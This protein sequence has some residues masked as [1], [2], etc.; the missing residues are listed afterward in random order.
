MFAKGILTLILLAT[1]PTLKAQLVPNNTKLKIENINAEVSD[2]RGFFQAD[3]L[4]I[5]WGL[6]DFD[7]QKLYGEVD[8][9]GDSL[10]YSQGA[11]TLIID[12]LTDSP[13]QFLQNIGVTHLNFDF[14]HRKFLFLNLN[15]ASFD[16]NEQNYQIQNLEMSCQALHTLQVQSVASDIIDLLYPCLAN[17]STSM[18]EFYFGKLFGL[19]E[20]LESFYGQYHEEL[21]RMNMLLN[22]SHEINPEFI[23]PRKL[24]DFFLQIKDSNFNIQARARLVLNLRMLIE[25][26]FEFINQDDKE[27]IKIEFNKATLARLPLRRIIL[28]G[29]KMAG[30]DVRGNSLYIEL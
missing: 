21:Q 4:N 10:I 30:F 25:G 1:L 7:Y 15:R 11:K 17:S 24:T 18:D 29:L 28:Q 23:L 20:S 14:I 13:F 6:F 3:Y 2:Y 9:R 12:E 27:I 5:K 19:N 8:K 16:W 22:E 26:H